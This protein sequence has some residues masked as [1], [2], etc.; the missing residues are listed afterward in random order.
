MHI[1][2]CMCVLDVHIPTHVYVHVS[3]HSYEPAHTHAY[4][5]NHVNV[6]MKTIL[7]IWL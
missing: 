1:D 4:A 3:D 5:L 2:M 6:C 7:N